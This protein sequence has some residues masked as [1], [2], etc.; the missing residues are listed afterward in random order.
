MKEH[1]KATSSKVS[2]A[3]GLLR[4][5]RSFLL[6]ENHKTLYTGIIE[7][8]SRYCCLV[9]GCSGVTDINQ[10]Q[11]RAA[12]SATGRSFDTSCQPLIKELGWKT[13]DLL[14]TSETYIMVYKYLDEL[15]CSYMCNLF[16]RES[17]LTSR[18]LI[19]TPTD[20]RLPKKISKTGEKCFSFR[21]AMTWNGF[22]AEGELA[23]S[24]SSSKQCT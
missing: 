11:N 6:G 8:H 20:L 19:N 22:S 5:V 15:A 4:H 18:C 14:I 3:I 24:L 7:S 10:L 23:S 12:Q 9:W 1:I 21:G 13:I 2:K 17:Y 16:T